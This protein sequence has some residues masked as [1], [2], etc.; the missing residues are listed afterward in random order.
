MSPTFPFHP[1]AALQNPPVGSFSAQGPLCVL[2]C[3]HVP[4]SHPRGG[5]RG[6]ENWARTAE[7]LLC[8]EVP[9]PLALLQELPVFPR[10]NLEGS[11]R[12]APVDSVEERAGLGADPRPR[13]TAAAGSPVLGRGYLVGLSFLDCQGEMRAG[14]HA[15]SAPQCCPP[16]QSLGSGRRGQML[17]LWP[18]TVLT[19]DTLV[20]QVCSHRCPSRPGFN[21]LELAADLLCGQCCPW[22]PAALHTACPKDSAD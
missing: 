13:G 20:Q 6:G 4:W 15:G 11:A 16:G 8:G 5:H 19:P 12:S 22:S 10:C 2:L 7:L 21:C 3:G 18:A 17:Q 1:V 9:A 14:A